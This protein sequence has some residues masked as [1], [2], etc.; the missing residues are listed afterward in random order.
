[1]VWNTT[2]PAIGNQVS[3]DIPDIQENFEEIETILEAITNGTLGT[4]AAGDFRVDVNGIADESIDSDMYVDGSIDLAHMSANSID[5]DQ[6]VDASIDLAHM[7]DESV[8]SDQ[9]VDGSID[10]AHLATDA[11]ETAKI[12]NANVDKDKLNADVVGAGLAG[13]AGTALSVDGI[14]EA[15]SVEMKMKIVDVGD[16]NMAETAGGGSL[17]HNTAH[18]LTLANIRHVSVLILND[19]GDESFPLDHDNQGKWSVDA[20]NVKMS[21]TDNGFFDG[22]DF[23]TPVSN[24]AGWITIW[25]TA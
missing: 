24:N 17:T 18:G 2:Q 15:G 11:V 14:V 13:G 7:S 6:Y 9:Y 20:T 22:A 8:D 4:T 5:S 19:D 25:Y 21:I 16:W 12:K 1:M 3:A 10:A 23:Q